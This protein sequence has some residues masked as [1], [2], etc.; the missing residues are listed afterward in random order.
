MTPAEAAALVDAGERAALDGAPVT[1]CPYRAGRG[2]P[3]LAHLRRYLW[4]R[5]YAYGIGQLRGRP[6]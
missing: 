2:D 1:A 6:A 5:G 4:C 3:P